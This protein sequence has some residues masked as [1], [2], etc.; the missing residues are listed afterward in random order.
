M[1]IAQE[2]YIAFYS[3]QFDVFNPIQTQVFS[4]VYKGDTNVLLA[5]PSGSGKTLCAELAIFRAISENP[6]ARC[7]YIAPLAA[8]AK[9][10]FEVRSSSRLPS[11][12]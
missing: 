7:V 11:S 10:R 2:K 4:T 6:A 9:E 1:D 8:I 5:A 12:Q 3:G